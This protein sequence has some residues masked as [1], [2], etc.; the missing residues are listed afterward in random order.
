MSNRTEET[1]ATSHTEDRPWP[2]LPDGAGVRAIPV[3]AASPHNGFLNEHRADT[4]G[5][6]QGEG[7]A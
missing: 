4:W 3:P 2:G 6:Y 1:M 5:W 7:P